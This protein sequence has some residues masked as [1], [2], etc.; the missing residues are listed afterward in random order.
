MSIQQRSRQ[1][2]GMEMVVLDSVFPFNIFQHEIMPL[3]SNCTKIQ[4][5][6]LNFPAFVLPVSIRKANIF[7]F[8]VRAERNP[9]LEWKGLTKDNETEIKEE[10]DLIDR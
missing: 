7:Y 4:W 10:I 2:H 3:L 8:V 5:C 6:V 1:C 9:Y